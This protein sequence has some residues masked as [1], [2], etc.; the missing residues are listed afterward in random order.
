MKED[1][2]AKTVEEKVEEI[3]ESKQKVEEVKANDNL[4]L[5]REKLL[6]I[7]T[8]NDEVEAEEL[9]SEELRAKKMLGGRADAGQPEESQEQ[10][11]EKEAAEILS[12][13]Q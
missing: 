7:K 4:T 9:R 5:M 13:L 11:D 12:E 10:K 3:V 1:K 6:E 8:I 2:P